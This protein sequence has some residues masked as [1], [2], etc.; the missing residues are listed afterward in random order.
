MEPLNRRIE[1]LGK[2]RDELMRAFRE[3]AGSMHRQLLRISRVYSTQTDDGNLD[4]APDAFVGA[5]LRPHGPLGGLAIGLREP[6]E[7]RTADAVG[8]SV[9]KR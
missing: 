9:E 5:R 6:D 2:F 3:R 7:E 1:G 8:F 4:D